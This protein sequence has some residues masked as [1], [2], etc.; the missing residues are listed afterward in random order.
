MSFFSVAVSVAA[1]ILSYRMTLSIAGVQAAKKSNVER[2]YRKRQRHEL[3]FLHLI[4]LAFRLIRQIQVGIPVA[5]V[6][7]EP[8]ITS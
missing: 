7:L 8:N 4:W 5:S 1:S 3:Q 6:R 2:K